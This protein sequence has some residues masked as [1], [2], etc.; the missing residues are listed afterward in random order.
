MIVGHP[1]KGGNIM[2]TGQ[3]DHPD[4]KRFALADSSLFV[5]P[6]LDAWGNTL[7]QAQPTQVPSFQDF[8]ASYFGATSCNISSTKCE[9]MLS[10]LKRCYEN[11]GENAMDACQYYIQGVE[12]LSS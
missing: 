5:P 8:F 3:L 11:N 1:F 2:S 10:G 9:N 12:R 6:R 7:G 4:M